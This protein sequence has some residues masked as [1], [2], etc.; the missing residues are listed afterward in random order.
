MIIKT[1]ENGIMK[2][3]IP[4]NLYSAN[5]RIIKEYSLSLEDCLL[6]LYL[7]YIPE[8]IIEQRK[9][10]NEEINQIE[11]L[12]GL[13]ADDLPKKLLLDA[14]KIHLKILE[15]RDLNVTDYP[16]SIIQDCTDALA[17]LTSG[18]YAL[19]KT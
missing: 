16:S 2:W 10:R 11:I 18:I 19:R 13:L 8:R 4:Q 5:R 3:K 14:K 6:K 15:S 17:K 1:Y 7:N 9:P 12:E